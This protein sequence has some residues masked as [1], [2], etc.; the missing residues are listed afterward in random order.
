VIY[1]AALFV[2]R[3]RLHFAD[4]V[5]PGVIVAQLDVT[6]IAPSG[7]V[8]CSLREDMSGVRVNELHRAEPF[9]A[10]R[11]IAA[12]AN[13]PATVHKELAAIRQVHGRGPKPMFALAPARDAN[14]AA[15]DGLLTGIG[16]VHD[17]VPVHARVFGREAE[18]LFKPVN[19]IAKPHH[20]VI[21]HAAV[22][23]PHGVPGAFQRPK[24]RLFRAPPVVAAVGRHVELG[25]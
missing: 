3:D 6:V 11:T 21:G 10:F 15:Q 4:H 14:P 8:P 12:C 24:R 5:A 13:G 20:Y 9:D 2:R 19:P 23:R 25:A 7:H 17:L 18:W 22:H 16:L 1:R